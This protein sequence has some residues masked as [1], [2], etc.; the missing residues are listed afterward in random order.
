MFYQ[1]YCL[2]YTIL[3][4]KVQLF[5]GHVSIKQMQNKQILIIEYVLSIRRASFDTEWNIDAV[6]RNKTSEVAII[7]ASLSA[8]GVVSILSGRVEHQPIVLPQ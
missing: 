4:V 7:R 1:M 5:S 3:F 6:T 2:Y 8:T